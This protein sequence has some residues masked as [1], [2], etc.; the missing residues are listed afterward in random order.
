MAGLYRP[1]VQCIPSFTCD[2]AGTSRT[3]LWPGDRDWRDSG[4]AEKPRGGFEP[5]SRAKP[6][7]GGRCGAGAAMGSWFAF[8]LEVASR[9]PQTESRIGAWR[10]SAFSALA[11][12]S[13]G[14]ALFE[15]EM[16][17][18]EGPRVGE[19]GAPIGGATRPVSAAPDRTLG[20][21]PTARSTRAGLRGPSGRRHVSGASR[22][23]SKGFA[24][25]RH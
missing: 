17:G 21:A 14:R 3:G 18:H 8:R 16:T 5:T 10:W 15:A 6:P 1:F 13:Q 12:A 23:R 9:R 19:P 7:T 11:L 25:A 24:R 2:S 4:S 22:R 20:R